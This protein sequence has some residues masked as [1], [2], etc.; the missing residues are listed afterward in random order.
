VR[1]RL[2]AI[3]SLVLAGATS[4]R[5]E[6]PPIVGTL[7]EDYLPALKPLLQMAVERSPN[8]IAASI[9][10]ALADAARIQAD[11]ALYP[12]LSL[13]SDYAVNT[14]SSGSATSTQKGLFYNVGISQPLFQFGALKNSA[15]IGQIGL[16]MAQRQY[17]EAYR[18][19]AI[20]IRKQYMALI[21]QKISV[22][23]AQFALKVS[24]E[25][26]AAQQA[27]FDSGSSSQAELGTFKIA[28]ERAQLEADRADDEFWYAK[29]VFTRLV[30]IDDLDGQLIS[31]ELPH[32]D[33]S[34]SVADAILTGFVGDGVESTFQSQVYQ[35]AIRQ[36]ELNYSIAKVRLL[37]KVS[38]AA[39]IAY[40]NYVTG[41]ASQVGSQAEGYSVGASWS[42]F[43]G[44]A[45]K[46]AKLTALLS[47]RLDERTRKTYIDTSI[48]SMTYMRHQLDFSSREMSI[49]EV[50]YSLID[51]EVKR[52]D[53]DK[54]LGFASQ[55]SIDSGTLNLYATDSA[56]VRARSN[57]F[58]QW[59]DFISL[60]GLDP[61]L[62]NI[63]PRYVR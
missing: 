35:M 36:Q 2:F 28:V 40:E 41:A 19:L 10:V 62:N 3:L 7:P 16:K 54:S 33:Y 50:Q 30:G 22:R 57:Y 12:Q 45:T 14:Q 56:M 21:V 4:L 11:S 15:A 43:D 42:I 38:A 6:A 63:S 18:T 53:Q 52:L 49:A 9:S 5:S 31:L 34:A 27:R 51:A 24:Q 46:S 55:A 37:P 47:K 20:S 60:A 25:S 39:S 48:D 8:T 61:A 58:S 1:I 17:A 26:L 44:F 29:R 13:S 32:P 59:T 23:N